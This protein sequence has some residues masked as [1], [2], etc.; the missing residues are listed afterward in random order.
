MKVEIDVNQLTQ[1]Q[2]EVAELRKKSRIQELQLQSVSETTIQ[3]RIHKDAYK[4]A[5][6]YLGTIFKK[7]GIKDKP[8]ADV[9]TFNRNITREN[10]TEDFYKYE[11][12]IEVKICAN[13]IGGFK[14][15]FLQVGII[16]EFEK[17]D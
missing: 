5:D 9:L 15:A 3:E 6:L 12:I 11:N 7:L 2:N 13:I 10:K 1:L 14:D 16:T 8:E 4:I 17:K